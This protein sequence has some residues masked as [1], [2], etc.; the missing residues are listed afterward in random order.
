[1][2][3][4]IRYFTSLLVVITVNQT[5]T[6]PALRQKTIHQHG[7]ANVYSGLFPNQWDA[8]LTKCCLFF[9]LDLCHVSLHPHLELSSNQA[10]PV[11]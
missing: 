7:R 4:S 1:M 9:I 6:R 10:F 3:F 5:K 8:M 2:L 11:D